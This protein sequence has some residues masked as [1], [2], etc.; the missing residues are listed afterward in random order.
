MRSCVGCRSRIDR[1][2]HGRVGVDRPVGQRRVDLDPLGRCSGWAEPSRPRRAR[3]VRARTPGS[4]RRRRRS[5]R[6]SPTTAS[7]P[8]TAPSRPIPQ[9]RGGSRR[10]RRASPPES[11]PG[12]PARRA[13]ARPA[14]SPRTR[15]RR[16][17]RGTAPGRAGGAGRG[18]LHPDHA[19]TRRR[20]RRPPE[21]RPADGRGTPALA[22]M[23]SRSPTGARSSTS[24][25]RA[26]KPPEGPKG[27]YG[28]AGAE[29]NHHPFVGLLRDAGLTG[30]LAVGIE[31]EEH[32]DPP[33]GRM[34]RTRTC[35]AAPR[36]G[37]ARAT[38]R[39]RRRR[40]AP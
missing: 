21:L 30:L 9:G 23:T 33:P 32:A 15:R 19:Q 6:H 4:G 27:A 37:A 38:P 25:A 12:R 31:R 24:A 20:L 10:A 22:S 11:R 26:T 14:A 28:L 3:R 16:R 7:A 5:A 13:G 39:T 8:R 1:E 40:S 18:G 29:R 35:A 2:V 17:S 34:S 36:T